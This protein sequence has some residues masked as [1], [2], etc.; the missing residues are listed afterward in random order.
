MS[1]LE[2]GSERQFENPYPLT[3]DAAQEWEIELRN[4]NGQHYDEV[5]HF[6]HRYHDLALEV[7]RNGADTRVFGLGFQFREGVNVEVFQQAVYNGL[8]EGGKLVEELQKVL[9][10]GSR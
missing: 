2:R 10:Y 8:A 1:Y 5:A 9:R 3:P 6:W 7:T 4:I